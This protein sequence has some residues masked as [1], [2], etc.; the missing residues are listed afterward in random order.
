MS[1]IVP[2][3][4]KVHKPKKAK[5][6][7]DYYKN[8]KGMIWFNAQNWPSLKERF[9]RSLEDDG[10]YTFQ[11]IQEFCRTISAEQKN[12]D[13]R[14]WLFKAIEPVV[15]KSIKH[16]GDWAKERL[17]EEAAH[18][19]QTIEIKKKITQELDL[20]GAGM[21][22]ASSY[23]NWQ[24]KLNKLESQV[25]AFFG[26]RAI[27]ER[28]L[29]KMS[30]KEQEDWEQT[31]HYR[32]RNYLS[33]LH[34]LL[35]LK[36]RVDES[37]L[38]AMGWNRP[39]LMALINVSQKNHDKAPGSQTKGLLPSKIEGLFSSYIHLQIEKAK[40]YGM[41]L[42]DDMQDLAAET[43]EISARAEKAIKVNGS[44]GRKL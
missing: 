21:M 33:V 34:K 1:K 6:Q 38:N 18:D 30:P 37:M 20:L 43:A 24:T 22:I 31:Q 40:T 25:E 11:T 16:Q 29:K 9:F 32:M 28:P 17:S 36:T 2:K 26:G 42:P 44:N 10:T 14:R 39:Q 7:K 8:N 5:R 41:E 27:L 3:I 35:N 12:E 23:G 15:H 19:P 4:W 13:A